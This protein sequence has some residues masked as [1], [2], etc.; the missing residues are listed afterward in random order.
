MVRK[1]LDIVYKEVRGLHQAAYVLAFFAF[2]SQ[3]LALL[4]DRMLAHEFGAGATLDIYYLAFRIPDLLF[5]LFASTLSVYVLIPFV[6]KAKKKGGPEAA[7]ALL[8]QVFSL[9]L[10][11]YS[12]VAVV[13]AIFLP[14]ITPILFPGVGNQELLI[15]VTRILLFQPLLLGMSSLFGVVTQLG[16]RFI[17][18]AVSPL[19]YN[20]GIIVGI[21]VFY[22]IFGVTG[23]ALGVVLG[24]LG[25]MLIQLPLVRT[26]ELRFGFV[27][28]LDWLQLRKVLLLSVPRALTLSLNQV[29]LLVLVSFASLMT[30]GSVSVFQFAYNLQSVPLAI[31]GVSYSVAV[32]PMLAELYN[33]KEFVKFGNHIA[34]ALRHIIFWSV[35]AIALIIVLRAQVVRVVLGSGAFDWSDTRLTAAVLA[36]LSLSLLAQAIN[37][38]IVRAF[39]AGGHTK[40]PFYI[41]VIGSFLA[42]GSAY[43]F[44]ALYIAHQEVHATI[45]TFMR[46]DNVIGS[47]VL[48]IAFGYALA[49]I[50]QSVLFLVTF[51]S[52]FKL[53]FKW[54]WEA[55]LHAVCAGFV[56][57]VAAYGAL[58]FLVDGINSGTFIGIF[59]QGSLAG[60]IGIVG[61]ILTYR[62]FRTPELFEVYSSF[63][64]KLLKTDV[65][66]PQEE[67]I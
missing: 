64:R 16:H 43:G 7:Q 66:A 61:I 54:I 11:A 48:A 9:F 62:A 60:L 56:G 67:I 19:I 5:V 49:V 32:F 4:R 41:T 50:A 25:H 28:K 31:I 27:T 20:I 24:A 36:L 14:Y 29:V 15:A 2:G 8:S 57:G 40:L 6:S 44:Y 30:V 42:V 10:L 12:V 33:R 45:A 53:P 47:E 22:P 23:L 17:L 52:F 58:N 35:P 51:S 55:I 18:Y 13:V 21:V 46:L 65:L 1:V 59:I 37:L 26:S 3:L 39:Y 63:Q 38:L 34:T